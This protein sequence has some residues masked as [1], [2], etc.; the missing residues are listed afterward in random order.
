MHQNDTR[1]YGNRY[2]ISLMDDS[3][4]ITCRKQYK[5]Q[6]TFTRL[7]FDMLKTTKGT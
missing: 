1:I 3:A 2:V 4:G 6:V 7:S 5:S